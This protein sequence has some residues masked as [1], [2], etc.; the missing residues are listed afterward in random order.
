MK[1][2]ARR[3]VATTPLAT[4][5]LAAAISPRLDLPEIVVNVPG[6]ISRN[7]DLV[8]GPLPRTIFADT[9]TLPA[10]TTS[11]LRAKMEFFHDTKARQWLITQIW[12]RLLLLEPGEEMLTVNKH[13]FSKDHIV[14]PRYHIAF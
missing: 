8:V 3:T 11:C 5:S 10:D 6:P 13:L 9:T 7:D 12:S 4:V 2:R 1:L 14:F